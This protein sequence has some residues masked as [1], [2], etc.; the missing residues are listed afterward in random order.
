MDRE[1]ILRLLLEVAVDGTVEGTLALGHAEWNRQ[2]RKSLLSLASA[3]Y[4][5]LRSE[6]ELTDVGLKINCVLTAKSLA[7]NPNLS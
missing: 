1:Y 5:E 2:I 3:G 6:L 4:L 7:L